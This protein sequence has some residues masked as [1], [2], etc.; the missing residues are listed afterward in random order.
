MMEQRIIQAQ[1]EAAAAAAVVVVAARR[2]RT[3]RTPRTSRCQPGRHRR[4]LRR[5]CVR[6]RGQAGFRECAL[7]P[8]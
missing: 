7:A 1:L 4:P 6:G 8:Y 3:S 2:R 5:G